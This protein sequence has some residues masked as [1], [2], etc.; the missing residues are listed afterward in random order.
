VRAPAVD[1]RSTGRGSGGRRAGALECE[2]CCRLGTGRRGHHRAGHRGLGNVG[3]VGAAEVLVLGGRRLR[4]SAAVGVVGAALCFEMREARARIVTR[5]M[6]GGGVGDR[7]TERTGQEEADQESRAEP[8]DERR[9]E[10]ECAGSARL[11][12]GGPTRSCVRV[13]ANGR[14]PSWGRHPSRCTPSW[15]TSGRGWSARRSRPGC[16]S[17]ARRAG[18]SDAVLAA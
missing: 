2:G 16:S 15:G 13:S 6:E 3:R 14:R 18:R 7:N 12:Q 4:Q 9:H 1:F 11:G 10:M 5:H 8:N 17:R